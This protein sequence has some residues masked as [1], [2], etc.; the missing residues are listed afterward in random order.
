LLRVLCMKILVTPF[1]QL[2]SIPVSVYHNFVLEERFGFN[3]YTVRTFAADKATS[4]LVEL[5]LEVLT[6]GPLVL[7]LRNLGEHAWLYA[8]AFITVFSLVFNMVYPIWIAPLTNKY[9]RLP[10]GEV[11]EGI[12]AVV[13]AS[14]LSCDKI[15]EVDG[16]RQSAHSN[17]AVVGF[18]FTKRILVYDTLLTHLNSDVRLICAVIA[19]EIGHA[20]MHHLWMQLALG[21]FQLFTTFFTFGFC[22]SV[23]DLVTDFGFDVPCTYLYLHCF[24]LLYS[25]ALMPVLTP[26]MSAFT[27]QLEFAADRYSVGLDFDIRPALTAIHQK[28][29][30][31]LDPDPLVSLVHHSHPTLVQRI[32]A[33]TR[34]LEAKKGKK[35]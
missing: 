23:P 27:R 11:R 33:V 15:F 31:D 30:S 22:R 20:K 14:G 25:S 4:F 35:E 16:S 12:E 28:N 26:L 13:A 17:A 19:H 5:V 10:D 3:K 24:F 21:T 34:C 9:T 6:M 18:F 29:L 2:T 7:L 32:T 1:E 8:W